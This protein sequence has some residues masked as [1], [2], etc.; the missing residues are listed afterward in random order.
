[1]NSQN[2]VPTDVSGPYQVDVSRSGD[3]NPMSSSAVAATEP[4][5]AY[6]DTMILN[7]E[8]MRNGALTI[9]RAPREK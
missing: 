7:G 3:S 2:T 9:S 5:K 8:A 1:M 6:G 4:R